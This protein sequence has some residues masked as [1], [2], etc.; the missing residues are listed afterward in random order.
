MSCQVRKMKMMA[1]ASCNERPAETQ[2]AKEVASKLAQLQ[3]ER[4]RQDEMWTGAPKS[5]SSIATKSVDET[6]HI[7]SYEAANGMGFSTF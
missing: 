3:A 5:E 6:H 1:A 4:A 2:C 7:K